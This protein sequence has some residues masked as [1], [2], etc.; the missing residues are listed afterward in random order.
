VIVRRGERFGVSVYEPALKRK[1]WVGTFDT[2]RD[3]RDAERNASRRKV[4]YARL[5]GGELAD[6]WL[7]NHPRP[8]VA[9]QRNYR[10]A[11]ASFRRHFGHVRLSELDRMTARAWALQQAQSNVRA[12]RA[13]LNDAINDGLYPGPT[14]SRICVWNNREAGKT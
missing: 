5:T 6:L 8:A 9:T 1:R 3:A 14:L 12:V 2:R 4:S 13:M 10:Y 7:A 11:L